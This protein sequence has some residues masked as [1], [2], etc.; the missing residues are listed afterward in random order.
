MAT[1]FLNTF[2]GQDLTT[3]AML[4]EWG[5]DREGKCLSDLKVSDGDA[6]MVLNHDGDEI[7]LARS[8]L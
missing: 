2:P 7:L 4:L 5:M 8:E 6:G 1:E 3:R